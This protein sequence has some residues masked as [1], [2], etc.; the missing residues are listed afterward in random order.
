M[1]MAK[2]DAL[3]EDPAPSKIER[4]CDRAN[5]SL[6]L[7]SLKEGNYHPQGSKKPKTED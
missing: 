5:R 3:V 1:R 2:A 4:K 6:F 7:S